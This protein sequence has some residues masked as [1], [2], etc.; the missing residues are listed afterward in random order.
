MKSLSQIQKNILCNILFHS[1]Q[2]FILLIIE[3]IRVYYK[4]NKNIE[5]VFNNSFKNLRIWLQN[6]DLFSQ[7]F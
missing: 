7:V 2:L 5:Y 3:I 1:F 6:M 4:Q